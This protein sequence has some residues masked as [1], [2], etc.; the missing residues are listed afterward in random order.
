M[1]LFLK[2]FK[3]KQ[4][5]HKQNFITP[6][7]CEELLHSFPD[8][9][10]IQDKSLNI[11]QVLNASI[12]L[13]P[14]PVKDMI[15]KNI[16]FILKNSP[17]LEDYTYKVETV[18]QTRQPQRFKLCLQIH[19]EKVYFDTY[20]T[21]ISGD[22]ILTFFRDITE[23][24]INQIEA[25]KLRSYLSQA[26]ENM[27]IPTSIKDMNTEKYIFWSKQSSI[28]GLSSEAILGQDETL[29]MEEKQAQK[30]QEFDRNLAHR[31]ASYQGIEKFILNDG[32]EHSLMITKNIFLH[33]KTKWL[34]CSSLDVTDMQQ[35]QEKIK[36]VTQKLMLA[37]HI[38]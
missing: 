32:K 30:A 33:G 6:S 23:S 3:K 13:F 11:I 36:S 35:Q 22:R 20:I 38:P 34:V 29:F 12:S 17:L 25:E 9:M 1:N 14:Y 21:T 10:F 31:N 26:L 18:L 5:P 28:F 7:L 16:G 15:G 24:T 2:C 4:T 8:M 19:G 27:A 37:L